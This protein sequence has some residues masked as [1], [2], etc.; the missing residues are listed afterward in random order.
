[1]LKKKIEPYYFMLHNHFYAIFRMLLQCYIDSHLSDLM[2]RLLSIWN[3]CKCWWFFIH[4]YIYIICCYF[5]LLFRVFSTKVVYILEGIFFS[6][7]EWTMRARFC[8]NK[9]L[10]LLIHCTMQTISTLCTYVLASRHD[11]IKKFRT[12][13]NF[14]EKYIE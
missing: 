11:M 14:N 5:A 1:M 7:R 6:M 2:I 4:V 8:K 13:K 10:R 3:G 9:R 12:I